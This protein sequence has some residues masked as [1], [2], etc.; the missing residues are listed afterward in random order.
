IVT[1]C[2][3]VWFSSVMVDPLLGLYAWFILWMLLHM[4]RQSL[5]RDRFTRWSIC[6]ALFLLALTKEMGIVLAGLLA[7]LG[8]ICLIGAP[9]GEDR[10]AGSRKHGQS[11]KI[12]LTVTFLLTEAAALISWYGYLAIWT[13][14]EAARAARAI[15]DTIGNAAEAAVTDAVS[16]AS[17][18]AGASATAT[19]DQMIGGHIGTILYKMSSLD[20]QMSWDIFRTYCYALFDS[21]R[22]PF[23]TFLP[24]SFVVIMLLLAAVVLALTI[25]R[26]QS[27]SFTAA[28]RRVCRLFAGAWAAGWIFC[29]CLCLAYITVFRSIGLTLPSMGRYLAPVVMMLI[30]LL[31]GFLTEREMAAESRRMAALL[32]GGFLLLLLYGNLAAILRAPIVREHLSLPVAEMT[33][34]LSRIGA[35]FESGDRIWLLK[36]EEG[37]SD[38][39]YAFGYIV[40]PARVNRKEFEVD[41]DE[42]T[43]PA[44]RYLYDADRPAGQRLF[45]RNGQTGAWEAY[46]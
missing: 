15:G 12:R 45:R 27:G 43:D 3:E 26:V 36:S 42:V 5:I 28:D 29:G 6:G 32:T 9:E 1:G 30:M 31:I 19:G 46:R 18:S 39:R 44:Y 33:A 25:R 8:P 40:M 2:F 22:A 24:L 20:S 35:H 21:R 23:G 13:R 16:N 11:G 17:G 7:V 34:E 4:D 10:N 14:V 38:V 41:R 37:L